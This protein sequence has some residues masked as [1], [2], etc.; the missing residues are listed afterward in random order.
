MPTDAQMTAVE[1]V[2]AM[3]RRIGLPESDPPE[4]TPPGWFRDAAYAAGI[5]P[6]SA[7]VQVY[8]R[9]TDVLAA[10]V[11]TISGQV[12]EVTATGGDAGEACANLIRALG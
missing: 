5:E 2:N 11:G 9:D 8:F 10:M 4:L 1:R 6:G 7:V 3:A 12:I